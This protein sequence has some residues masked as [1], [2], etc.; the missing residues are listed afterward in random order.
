MMQTNVYPTLNK[1]R[2]DGIG[3]YWRAAIADTIVEILRRKESEKAIESVIPSL[4]LPF[5][6][7]ASLMN[8][9]DDPLKEKSL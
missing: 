7:V 9:F 6:A 5:I 4:I 2:D 1:I 8:N 3:E